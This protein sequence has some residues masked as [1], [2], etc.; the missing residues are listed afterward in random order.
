[1]KE[2]YI[3]PNCNIELDY[4]HQPDYNIDGLYKPM[5]V[6]G[7]CSYGWFVDWRED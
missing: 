2:K 4:K 7:I 5:Y 6:C 1:M 3:C